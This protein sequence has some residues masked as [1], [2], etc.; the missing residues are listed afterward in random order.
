MPSRYTFTEYSSE[1]PH[2]FEQEAAR[3]RALLGD[4]LLAVHHIGSTSVPGLAAKPTID[5]IPVVRDIERIDEL[6]PSLEEAG[7]KAWGEYGLPERRFFTRDRDGFR[8]HNVHI[9][10][11]GN[12]EIERHLAFCAYLRSHEAIRDEYAVLKRDVFARHP[13]DIEAYCDGKDA[14]IKRIQGEALEWYRQR[15][16]F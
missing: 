10:Q 1:W 2:E 13:A 9:Y 11:E 6:T 3:L 4:E 7:Y 14:W 16:S 15:S 8:T 12:P 5:V